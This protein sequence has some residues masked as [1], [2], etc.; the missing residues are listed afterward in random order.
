MFNFNSLPIL[1][2]A[3][4]LGALAFVS[5]AAQADLM[6][7]TLG[8]GNSAIGSYPAPYGTV[9]VDLTGGANTNTAT[10]TFQSDDVGKYDYFFIDFSAADVNVNATTWTIGGFSVIQSAGFHT[11]TLSDG[12]SGNV[13]GF[14]TFNQTTN[15][16]DG[17]GSAAT[18]LDFTLTDTSGTWANAASVLTQN[19]DGW[20]AAAHIGVCDTSVG[21]GDCTSAGNQVATGYAAAPA[22]PIGRG[23]PVVLAAGGLLFGFRLRERNQ[24]RRSLGTA[25]PHA[26]A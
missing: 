20:Y 15:M 19:A 13:D 7:Y 5:P 2:G 21:T 24:K 16:S 25:F 17:F 18:E 4:A 22:P 10:I 9:T 8:A 11:A 3:A 14:G 12:G 1:A 26:A 23:L 6:D